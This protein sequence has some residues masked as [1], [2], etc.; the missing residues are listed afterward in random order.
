MAG[1]EVLGVK[2]WAKSRGEETMVYGARALCGHFLW[3]GGS[4]QMDLKG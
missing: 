1:G 4:K 2:H 3:V